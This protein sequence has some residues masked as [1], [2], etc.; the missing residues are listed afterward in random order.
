MTWTFFL[1]VFTWDHPA[2][3]SRDGDDYSVTCKSTTVFVEQPL[4]K[5]VGL[6]NT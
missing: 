3:S 4:A 5:T 2:V 1:L 6:L